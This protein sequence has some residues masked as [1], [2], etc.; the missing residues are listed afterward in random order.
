[1]QWNPKQSFGWNPH[2]V[3][4]KFLP[5]GQ[6]LRT[7]LCH[8]AMAESVRYYIQSLRSTALSV[9]LYFKWNHYASPELSKSASS[10]QLSK[11]QYIPF[12]SVISTLIVRITVVASPWGEAVT[13]WLNRKW[14]N[15]EWCNRKWLMRCF[16]VWL[17]FLTTSSTASGPPS[18]PR[19]RLSGRYCR[20]ICDFSLWSK[21][22]KS[23]LKCHWSVILALTVVVTVVASPWGEAG[24]KW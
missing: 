2:V 17:T 12:Q 14:W 3:R 15:H 16:Y 13:K 11:R 6:K 18:P 21:R 4:M 10:M 19:G 9:P 1:M 7:P 20:G 22:H 8:S 5:C 24:T 23:T